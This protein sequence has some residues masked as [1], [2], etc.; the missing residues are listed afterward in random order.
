[1]V[2]E[3]ILRHGFDPPGTWSVGHLPPLTFRRTIGRGIPQTEIS[4]LT[5]E[6][7]QG[8]RPSM[9]TSQPDR[10]S[11]HRGPDG[12]HLVPRRQ[13]DR[14]RADHR[15]RPAGDHRRP[16]GAAV[17]VVEIRR[18]RR[19]PVRGGRSG[20]TSLSSTP[21]EASYIAFRRRLRS[22]DQATTCDCASCRLAPRFDLKFFVHHGV[23]HPDD[24]RSGGARRPDVILVHR[25]L[26]VATAAPSRP[27][28]FVLFTVARR[29]GPSRSDPGRPPGREPIEHLGDVGHVH[30]GS[31]G[32][33]AN[34]V[35]APRLSRGGGNRSSTSLPRLPLSRRRLGALTSPALR[36]TWDGPIAITES[37][38]RV[39][40]GVGTVAPCVTGS[41]RHARGD[42]RLAAV[43]PPSWRLVVP[44]IGPVLSTCDLEEREDRTSDPSSLGATRRRRRTR[45]CSRP[46]P[47]GT[48]AA[49]ARL[50]AVSMG[51]C[52]SSISRRY[53][54]C[55]N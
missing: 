41:A 46:D 26:K 42:R 20:R 15:G 8:L 40:A 54:A 36:M 34:G 28:G 17:P 33:M 14:A 2:E 24:R 44:D 12:L 22:I 3:Q 13:R 37:P 51:R 25:L 11:R 4:A 45:R 53:S 29:G 5:L 21:I 50:V 23:R 43:R 49:F 39:D 16:T 35:G 7:L 9:D 18:R 55:P 32:S 27:D 6:R 10:I 1:M 47:C 19:V 38:C 30:D 52:R 31:R 48:T